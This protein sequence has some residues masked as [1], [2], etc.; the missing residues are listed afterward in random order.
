MP[1]TR[2]GQQSAKYFV[3]MA[4]R[5]DLSGSR[6]D[7][8]CQTDAM[9]GG[10]AHVEDAAG[11]LGDLPEHLPRAPLIYVEIVSAKSEVGTAVQKMIAQIREELGQFPE[12]LPT[13]WNIHRLHSDRGSELMAKELN[14][15]CN[16]HGIRRTL[17][18][19]YDPSA[20]GAAE[21]AVGFLKR[22]C[23]HLLAGSRLSTTWWGVA[24]KTA[25]Y[26]A[27]CE[28][29]L[30]PYPKI[31]FGTRIMCVRDPPPRDA[32]TARS[33]CATCFGPSETVS[34]GYVVYIDGQL[35]DVT[36]ISVT[37]L[38]VHE[39]AFVKSRIADWDQPIGLQPSA[40]TDSF[41]PAAAADP[42]VR[43]RGRVRR[44]PQEAPAP[45]EARGRDLPGDAPGDAHLQDFDAEVEELEVPG[46]LPGDGHLL[47][48]CQDLEDPERENLAQ[49][50]ERLEP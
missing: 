26:Y 41:D 43:P 21:Q 15:Y 22:K 20:N 49:K 48:C 33:S 30:H 42:S 19:G 35:R 11:E 31:P 36:N 13:H 10:P 24:T 6:R 17:T 16:L 5:P 46:L 3:V 2:I 40:P 14:D 8:S 34:G 18:Q 4:V 38:S 27:R 12:S 47:E 44:G 25:A 32:F 29:G 23:R 39:V 37:D 7:M 50:A 9:D 1:G 28:A 45:E